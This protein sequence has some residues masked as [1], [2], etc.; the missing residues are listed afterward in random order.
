VSGPTIGEARLQASITPWCVDRERGLGDI[1]DLA[2]SLTSSRATSSTREISRRRRICPWC[3]DLGMAGMADQ[4]HVAALAVI[5]PASFVPL[6]TSGQVA[7]MTCS[8]RRLPRSRPAWRR[9]GREDRGGAGRHSSN[10][11]TKRAPSSSGARPMR[12]CTICGAHIPAA[13]TSPAR[14]TI[15][16]A[17]ST[18]A[19]K[20]LG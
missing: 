2:G 5:A 11:S 17:R 20:P 12:L 15:S 13:H 1:G 18:P 7:S 3:L 4:D 9:H 6:E 8:S 14:S 10:S 19:Q 16:I